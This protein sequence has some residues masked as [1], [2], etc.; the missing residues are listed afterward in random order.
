MIVY[1]NGRLVSA[2]EPVISPLDHGFLYG[3]G[4]FETMRV[5]S[6]K[7][8]RLGSHLARLEAAASVLHWPTLP[9]RTELAEAIMS[10]LT[11][12]QL[13]EASVRLTL[14]RGVGMPRPDPDSC[15]QPLVTIF[16][17]PLPPPLP[18]GGWDVI[19]TALKR[20]LSSPLV[21]IKSANYLDNVLAKAEAKAKGV[22]EAL[23]LNT[24]GFVAEGT[25]SNLFFVKEGRLVT[26]DENSGILPGITRACIIELVKENEIPIEVRQVKL[27]ELIEADEIF[28]TSSIM[29]VIPVRTLEGRPTGKEV[30][31]PVTAKLA[32]L[33]RELTKKE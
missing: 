15:N 24:D 14:S 27:Q 10:V 26:P 20:N 17:S 3:H 6:G 11:S 23:M 1:Y 13:T 33:Y 32:Q 8:F 16:A 30:P 18:N 31:G 22:H 12:N 5:Y 21:T 4:L 25:M 2:E 19:V 7:V 28:L 9:T 29:E